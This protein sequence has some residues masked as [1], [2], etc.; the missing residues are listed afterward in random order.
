[1]KSQ[2]GIWQALTSSLCY[3]INGSIHNLF[4]LSPVFPH[5]HLL[6][7]VFSFWQRVRDCLSRPV[8]L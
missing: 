3:S 2:P 4:Q 8:P 6:C 7:E 5:F 1:M